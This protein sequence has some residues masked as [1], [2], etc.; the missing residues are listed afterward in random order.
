MATLTVL[1][2]S[3]ENTERGSFKGDNLA[4]NELFLHSFSLTEHTTSYEV[5]P[6]CYVILVESFMSVD[7]YLHNGIFVDMRRYNRIFVERYQSV[8]STSERS[9]KTFRNIESELIPR[10]QRFNLS[11]VLFIKESDIMQS[12]F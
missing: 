11:L 3:L 8:R 7:V 2:V 1:K 6:Y 5:L 9:S 12:N 4:R 10:G